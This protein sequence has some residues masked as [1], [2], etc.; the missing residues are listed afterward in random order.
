MLQ[1][2]QG[3][4]GRVASDPDPDQGEFGRLR[5]SLRCWAYVAFKGITRLERRTVTVVG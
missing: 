4:A 3:A 2:G 1:D 5:A